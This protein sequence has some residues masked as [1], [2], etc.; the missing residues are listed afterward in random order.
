MYTAYYHC[1][2]P[3]SLDEIKEPLIVIGFV[4]SRHAVI[5]LVLSRHT[6]IVL[7][8]SRHADSDWFCTK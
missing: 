7:V 1:G 3:D 6:V 8:L 4:L 2:K 5:V